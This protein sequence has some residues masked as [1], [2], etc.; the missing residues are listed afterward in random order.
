M[1]VGGSIWTTLGIAPTNEVDDIRRAYARR[2]KQ[3]HPEDD[4]EGFQALRSAYEQAS[5]MARRG[6][7]A[8]VVAPSEPADDDEYNDD[9][10]FM[11]HGGHVWSAR[12]EN[13]QWSEDAPGGDWSA[14]PERAWE[15]P[16][17]V[18]P[19]PMAI[20]PTTSVRNWKASRH[21]VGPMPRCAMLL[22]IRCSLRPPHLTIA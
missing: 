19:D 22:S 21:G 1:A 20:W 18:A 16:Q 7:A 17:A 5:N 10:G 9:D 6:W 14:P 12:P 15:Q 4:P 8:P 2:L 11:E 13:R 3:V